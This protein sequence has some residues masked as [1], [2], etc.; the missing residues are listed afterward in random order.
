MSELTVANYLAALQDDPWDQS[1]VQGLDEALSSGDPKRLGEDPV[2]LLEFARRNHEVRGEAYAAAK[3]I[4]FELRLVTNDP[5]FAA[6]LWRELGRLRREDLMDDEGAKVAYEKAIEL[7]PGEEEVQRA[8]EQIA[9]VQARWQEIAQHFVEQADGASDAG[10]RTQLL[11][12]A[13]SIV[14]QYKKKGKNKDVERLFREALENDPASARAA[15]LYGITLRLREKWKELGEVLLTSA[16]SVTGRDDQLGMH[17]AAA[18]VLAQRLTDN[19]RAAACYERV[20]ELLPA[21]EESLGFLVA[22]FTEREEW[23]HL[24]ALYEDALRARQLKADA[25]QGILLQIGMVHWRM[26]Q[27]HERAEPYFA[28]LRKADPAQPVMLDFYRE[29]YT[30]SGETGRLLSVLS[31]AQRRVNH[32]PDKVKLSLEIAR[33]AQAD[34]HAA[35]RAIDAFKHVLR[36]DPSHVEAL[37]SL[38]QLYRRSGKWNALVEVLRGELDNLASDDAAGRL[39]QLKELLAIYRDELKLDA[40]VLSTYNTILQLDPH[41]RE[42]TDELAKTYESLGRWNDLI[43]VLMREADAQV[44]PE[45]K[46]SLYLRVARLWIEHFSNYNQATLPLEQVIAVD[47]NNRDALLLLKEIYGKKRTWKPLF[48]VLAK[49]EALSESAQE[50]LALLVELATIAGEK[51]HEYSDA[52]A[53]WRRVLELDPSSGKALDALEKLAERAKDWDALADAVERRVAE[54]SDTQAKIKLLTRLGTL[55]AE[56]TLDPL[57]AASAW[58]RVLTLDV[59]NG[60]AMRTLRESYLAAGDFASVETLYAEAHDWD[61]FVD[62]LGTAADKTPDNELKKTLSFR[63]AEVYERELQ[64]PARAF[65]SY[66]RVLSVEPEN[67]RAVRALLPLYEKDEKWPRVAQLNEILLKQVKAEQDVEAARTLHMRLVELFQTKLR[68][69]EKAFLHASAAYALAPD[70]ADVQ[71]KLEASADLSGAYERLAALYAE[72][73][74]AISA[75]DA[76]VL[77]RRISQLYLEKLKN[78]DRAAAELEKILEVQ[79]TDAEVHA[80]LERIYRSQSRPKSLSALYLKQLEHAADDEARF[81]RRY[82]LAQVAEDLL[83]DRKGAIEHYQAMQALRPDDLP[84]LAMLDRLLLAESRHEE[85]GAVLDRRIELA[86]TTKEKLELTLRVGRLSASD[87]GDTDR[88]IAAFAGVLELDPA[89]P[90]AVEALEKIATAKP[91]EVFRVGRLLEPVY[92]RTHKLDKLQEV[93]KT[94]LGA[95]TDDIEKRDLKLRL[96][97]ISGSLGDPKAAYATLESA[98]LDNPQSQDLWERISSMADQAHAH[99]ELAVAFSTAIEMAS[100]DVEAIAALSER[101][102]RIYDAVLGQP[103][104]AEPFHARVL[105]Q[106]PLSEV[107]YGA[108]RE[109]YTNSERWED[110]KR[111]YRERIVNTLDISQKLDLLLQVCFLHEEILDDVEQAITSYQEVLALDPGHSTS[112]RAL[113]RLYTRAERYRELVSLLEY[114]RSE[115]AGKEAIEL[116]FRIGELYEL[117]LREPAL[118][119][120]QHALV[121]EEQPTHLRAQEALERLLHTESQRQRIAGLLE[122]LYTRQ[123]AYNELARILEVQLEEMPEPGARVGTFMRLGELHERELKD[124]AQALRSYSK[125]VELDPTDVLARRELARLSGL[126]GALSD[127]AE[128]LESALK[129]VEFPEVRT[130]ILG[131]LAELWDVLVGNVERAI[132][133]YTRLI[134]SD[135]E[136]AEV[137]LPAARAL[138]RLH[139]VRDDHAS[140]TQALRLQVTFEEELELKKALLG[141]LAELSEGPLA[142]VPAA[143][144]AYVERLDLDSADLI[145]MLALERLYESRADWSS[146]IEILQKRDA[147]SLNEH[148]GRMLARRVGEVYETKLRDRERAIE[149]YSEVLSRFGNDRETLIALQRVYQAAERY[150]DLLE[151]LFLELDLATDVQDR[152]EVRFR[153]AELMRKRTSDPEAALDAYRAVLEERPGHEATIGALNE[154]VATGGEARVDAARV[155]VPHYELRQDH[156]RLICALEVVAESDDPRECLDS[157]RKA[158]DA[159]ERGLTDNGRAYLLIARAVRRAVGEDDLAALLEELN[160]LA[161]ASGRFEAYASLLKEIAPAI[162]DEE[163]RVVVFMRAAQVSRGLADHSVAREYFEQALA[164]RPDHRPALDALEALHLAAEDHRGLLGVLRKKT[165]LAEDVK[166]RTQLLLRQAELCAYKL[167]DVPAAIEAYEQVLEE[168]PAREVFDGLAS[169]YQRGER[170]VDLATMYERQMDLNIGDALVIR[171][172]LAEVYRTRLS[173]VERALDL[174]QQV[175]E[176]A[177]VHEETT[178]ALEAL[179]DDARHRPQAAALLEP[180]Y[181]RKS[182]WPELTRALEAQLGGDADPE[183]KKELLHRLAQLHEV[184]LEDLD[185]ALETYARLFRVEPSE[186]HAWDALARLSRVLGK[187]ERVAEVYEAYLDEVGLEDEVGVRLAVISAQIRDQ[188]GRDLARASALYQRALAFEPTALTVADALEDVLLR[189]RASEELKAFYRT[190]SE[191]ATDDVR[192]VSCLHKLAKVLET[193]LRDAEGGIRVYQEILELVSEDALAIA[194]LDRLLA[195]TQSWSG[196]AEHVQYQIDRATRPETAAQLKLRLSKLYEEHLDDVNL[197]IDTYEDVTRLEPKNREARAALERLSARPE[198]LRRVAEILEPLY[199]EAGEWSRQVWLFEKLVGSETDVAE[200]SRLFGE[201]AR[202]HEVHGKSPRE[203]LAAW[204][205]ALVTDPGDEHARAEIERLANELSDWDALVQAFEDAVES[206]EDN[207][208]KASLLAAVAR[209]HDERRGDPRSAITAYERLIQFETDDTAPFHQLEALLTMVGDWTGLVNLFKRKVERAYDPLERA[210][211]WR[212]AGSVLD[213]LVGDVEGA[214]RAYVAALEEA[215]DD[216][217][218]LE[219]LDGLYQRTEDYQALSDV[220]RRRADFGT[221]AEERIDVNLRLGRVLAERLNRPTEA[222]DAYVRVCDEDPAQVEAIRA[223]AKLYQEESLWSDLLDTLRRQLEI[224]TA[225][226]DKLALFYRIGQVHDERQSEFDDAIEAYREALLLDAAHEPSIKAL[227]RIGEQADQRSRVEEILEPTLRN[228][229]RWDDLAT[230]LSRGVSSLASPVDRQERLVRLAEIHEQGRADLAAAFDTL[231]EALLV[232]ADDEKLPREVERV[233]EA[234]SAWGRATDVLEHR[235]GSTPDT[236]IA[237]V[238][239]GRVAFI[240][241]HHLADAERA[242]AA[243]ERALERAGD[244][245]G[246]LAEL[247]RLYAANQQHNELADILERRVLS[248]EGADAVELLVRLGA[249]RE[250]QFEDPRGALTAYREVIDREPAEA[251]ATAALER[252][253]LNPDLAS[254]VVEVLDS[255]YRETG[256]LERVA[257]LYETRVRQAGSQSERVTLLVDLASLLERDIGDLLRAAKAMRRAFEADPSDHGLLDDIERVAVESANFEVLSGLIETATRG[258]DVSRIDKRDLWM[259]GVSWYRERLNDAERTERGLRKALELDPD[260]E[261]AHEQL[262]AL[263]RDQGQHRPLVEAL[264]TW[265][266]RD[267]DHGQA[268]LRLCEAAAIAENGAGDRERAIACYERV[269]ELDGE[270][271][272]ALD[273]LI[274]LQEAEGRLGKVAQLYDRRIDAEFGPEQRQ[275]LR[276]RAA[277]LRAEQLDD[278]DGAIRLHLA[279]LED[280]PSDSVSLAALEQFYREAEQWKELLGILERRLEVASS[281]EERSSARVSL[282]LLSEQQLKNTGRAIEELREVLIENPDHGQAQSELLRLLDSENRY[283]ELVDAL[284]NYVDRCRDQGQAEAELANLVR[285]G[286]VIDERLGDRARAANVYERVL[287]GD[288]QHVGALRALSELYLAEGDL[289]RAAEMLERRLQCVQGSER[290]DVAYRLAELFETKLDSRA[291]A[292]NALRQALMAGEREPDTRERLGKL[293]E[294]AGDFGAL[295]TLMA[296]DVERTVDLQHKVALLRRISDLYRSKLEDAVSASTYLER[297]SQLVPDDRGVLVPLCELYIAAGRQVDAVPVLEKIIASFGGRRVKELASFHHMLALAFQGLGDLDRAVQ[298]LDAAY[299][300]DLTNVAVLADLGLLAL[301]RGDLERAQTTFRR[302]LLQKLDKDAPISKADVYFYLGDISHQQG[303]KAKA[304]SMLERAVAEHSQHE[305]ARSLLSNLKAG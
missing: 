148:E 58:K 98:F 77:R 150:Q 214:I 28:R 55:H 132:D 34:P 149:A 208:L 254:E 240:A 122:P 54:T 131:E 133:A 40:M 63:A 228:H 202:L 303:D 30:S 153:A 6:V 239:Y 64:E 19:E 231:C 94:R 243:N 297:A 25:E 33:I 50:K 175:L 26:L 156:E 105:A 76:V 184:Q 267:S 46:V 235:A 93:L 295:A 283:E 257:E 119:V 276:H 49:E 114:D 299:R 101:T 219:A 273:E 143:I 11:V 20:L 210:E 288:P 271:L 171:Y 32:E 71:A 286:E 72:R 29:L 41:N 151:T 305:R 236:Q 116:T 255:V 274:R 42:A 263:L 144:G 123:G 180:V 163:L 108:L 97:E 292:E 134:A 16:K 272:N 242:I 294:R 277:T 200:R 191:V 157:L 81:E 204:R 23:E 196:L 220:L 300:V 241:E 69:G 260:F 187:Q 293:F 304:I 84:T 230:L 15:R 223:L 182:K 9:Q 5:D 31:D 290:V 234:L 66:E 249:L 245:A 221:S 22:H 154:M 203:A 118:A 289:P 104:K 8:L 281:I 186:G 244:D 24:V 130:E 136:N 95:S 159:A 7:R 155:L 211:L 3:L 252:L 170:W 70:D 160:R 199:T 212:R 88:A 168:S 90:R 74:A 124:A 92:E 127:R 53:L 172:K 141:R 52:I 45:R 99:E 216:T 279:N 213:D 302:L 176:R 173:E 195:E 65:R 12:R 100:L 278:R 56:R 35:E 96:A 268:V 222:I 226:A 73:A 282:A 178:H 193:E 106:D 120:D 174:Y 229:Q 85:L 250:N 285:L 142:D 139:Q 18:R 215:D 68:D 298:E 256:N 102:A 177:P 232:D 225:Q 125:A 43:P 103:E 261:P 140:L 145:A 190:Q 165:D 291:G 17:L 128:L 248:A 206:T 227:L 21:H 36:H 189:R 121:L 135:S 194:A 75:E 86:G 264:V 266:D 233:A 1:A 129:R 265:A 38:K 47:P 161:H 167:D 224:E 89:D 80:I 126:V 201:I 192:R 117:K 238:L 147:V 162:A 59:K 14:W 27:R 13:A 51:L 275:A 198:L 152:A 83:S 259:R 146:L 205:R 270:A 61:G 197:A 209:A 280:D 158:A 91:S 39:V 166:E 183:Q 269:L 57:R 48:G 169:L 2:R 164:L 296:E 237:Q 301:Q 258:A 78:A 115:A 60:R 82:A 247:D 107:A 113:E 37:T 181:L 218:S 67:V 62:V 109:L 207:Q 246:V 287:E 79:P 179:M 4:E 185:T 188:F 137:V 217:L 44:D 111:L 138:E 112:R 253:L 110:L 262:I 284:E 251:R 10:L 87:L